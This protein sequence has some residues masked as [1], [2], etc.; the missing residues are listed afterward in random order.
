MGVAGNNFSSDPDG[1][2]AGLAHPNFDLGRF[3]TAREAYDQEQYERDRIR[4]APNNHFG[5]T[6]VAGYCSATWRRAQEKAVE[7]TSGFRRSRGNK[8]LASEAG[9]GQAD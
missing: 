3:A 5:W 7:I 4:P 6:P 1:C 8:L 9:T 2:L